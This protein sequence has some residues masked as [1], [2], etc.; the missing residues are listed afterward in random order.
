MCKALSCSPEVPRNW[1]NTQNQDHPLTN[2]VNI[3]TSENDLIYSLGTGDGTSHH[4]HAW[5]LPTGAFWVRVFHWPRVHYVA[6]AASRVGRLSHP[7]FYVGSGAGALTNK[8][9]SQAPLNLFSIFGKIFQWPW[10]SLAL[11]KQM[12][13]SL[14]LQM[15]ANMVSALI[16]P[17]AHAYKQVFT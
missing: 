8:P 11:A 1:T 5:D 12:G 14:C 4:T 7:A 6:W 3:L 10:H 2:K 17:W 15:S 16:G 13:L 9:S